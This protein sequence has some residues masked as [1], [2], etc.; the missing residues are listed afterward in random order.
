[1]MTNPA[2]IPR[3]LV[4]RFRSKLALS[5][6]D[7]RRRQ[8]A[9]TTN[10]VEYAEEKQHRRRR[11]G[12]AKGV[13]YSWNGTLA[14]PAALILMLGL[15][16]RPA[17]AEIIEEIAARVND[18]LIARSELQLRRQ[19]IAV[20]LGQQAQGAEL[21]R[22][23]DEAQDNALFDLIN[24]ELLIQQA[25]L[26]FDMDR[27]FEN[28]KKEFKE[29]NEIGTDRELEQLLEGEGLTVAE[30]RRILLRSNVPQ[31]V[32]Q[33]EVARKISVSPA[34]IEAYYEEDTSEFTRAG[35]VTLREIV[36]LEEPRGQEDARTLAGE[37]VARA[38]AGEDFALLAREMSE[39]P[40]REK[41]G[42]VGPFRQGDLAPVLEE[43]AF[44][45][46][47][48]EVGEP[49]ATSYGFHIVKVESRTDTELAPLAEVSDE[50]EMS[51]R[52]E[53]YARDVEAY[54]EKLWNENLVVVNPR[55]AVGRL[56]DGGPYV[57]L[58]QILPADS[59]LGAPSPAMAGS[60]GSPAAPRSTP[61]DDLAESPGPAM[62]TPIEPGAGPPEAGQGSPEDAGDQAPG[63][64]D[65]GTDSPAAVEPPP[66]PAGAEP[67]VEESEAEPSEPRSE[68][69]G[70]EPSP[71]PPPEETDSPD[72][73]REKPVGTLERRSDPAETEPADD[74]PAEGE[75]TPGGS[76]S[77]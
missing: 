64:S 59:P 58:E 6:R 77:P 3:W 51:I 45:L 49:I 2:Q 12:P 40:S 25:A 67:P 56:A 34:E 46:A 37:I 55:Y 57:T 11:G 20:Q 68:P 76:P 39:A 69:A 29:N 19:Q 75:T 31:D 65:P 32:L 27:Y 52:Q 71:E 30:F 62:E 70:T 28:L 13:T 7:P 74:P 24:E 44:R 16:P 61:L 23:V 22:L 72:G 17:P 15:A 26:N 18:A 9:S 36:I 43:Q 42:L 41:G 47:V 4:F 33:F 73:G 38:A 14:F 63:A 5:V 50:I 35:D 21:E 54:L 10:T 60:S 1:M 48:G 8:G 53:K 66:A